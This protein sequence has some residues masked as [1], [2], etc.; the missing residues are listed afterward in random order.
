MCCLFQRIQAKISF[1]DTYEKCPSPRVVWFSQKGTFAFTNS[2][3]SSLFHTPTSAEFSGILIKI[4]LWYVLKI[5]KVHFVSFLYIFGQIRI[6]VEKVT[7]KT[8]A[9][10]SSSRTEFFKE[11]PKNLPSFRLSICIFSLIHTIKWTHET[12]SSLVLKN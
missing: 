11:L 6:W 5:P 4:W 7:S 2:S 9:E 1:K 10:F 8:A 12:N 3:T